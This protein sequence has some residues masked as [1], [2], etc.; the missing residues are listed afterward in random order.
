MIAARLQRPTP[1][2]SPPWLVAADIARSFHPL[3]AT[4]DCGLLLRDASGYDRFDQQASRT[5]AERLRREWIKNLDALAGSYGIRRARAVFQSADPAG[6]SP[7]ETIV[8][9]C[10][11][12]ILRKPE[13]LRSQYEVDA[14]G[15]F[16]L[17]FAVPEA[18]LAIEVTGFGKFGTRREEAYSV[19]QKLVRRQQLLA[20]L[21]YTTL[22]VTYQQARNP[23]TLIR[24]LMRRLPA[25]GVPVK[26]PSGPCWDPSMTKVF[27]RSRRF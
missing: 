23:H 7:G 18:G 6:E 13:S 22:N 11:R 15:R 14:G 8:G 26:P 9:W 24:D 20:D 5:R 21:G 10:L 1:L 4:H 3:Q 17:D 16:F 12:L 25:L 27:A 2:S 19:G